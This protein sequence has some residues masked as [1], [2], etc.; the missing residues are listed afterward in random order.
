MVPNDNGDP[1][2]IQAVSKTMPPTR[3]SGRNYKKKVRTDSGSIF[4]T[5]HG[6][7]LCYLTCLF[8]IRVP[9][10]YDYVQTVVFSHVNARS[11][12]PSNCF[13]L[14]H[15]VVVLVGRTHP[16]E[17]LSYRIPLEPSESTLIT[18]SEEPEVFPSQVTGP[19][20]ESIRSLSTRLQQ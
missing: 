3:K 4:A 5:Y 11:P 1:P 12:C 6:I 15:T 20:F 8:I 17:L 13:E 10:M 14:V 7:Y 19:L 9:H 16:G 2:S 18:A